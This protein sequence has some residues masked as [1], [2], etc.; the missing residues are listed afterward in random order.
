MRDSVSLCLCVQIMERD[1]E[2]MVR[3]LQQR[4]W[5]DRTAGVVRNRK[6]QVIKGFEDSK[7]YLMLNARF[8]GTRFVNRLHRLVWV[9]VYGRFPKLIDHINGNPK[10]N[11]IENL[12]EVNQSENDMNRVWAWK[13]NAKT[14]LPGVYKVKGVYRVKVQDK[15]LYFRDKYEAFHTLTMLGRMWNEE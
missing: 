13:P 5:Y 8:D 7:G 1:R 3:Y 12:R 10:D 14:G 4:Y 15:Q 2:K 6:G 9:L 11:R